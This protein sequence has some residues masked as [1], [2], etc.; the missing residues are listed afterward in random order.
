MTPGWLSVVLAIAYDWRLAVRAIRSVWNIASDIIVG[1]DGAGRTWGGGQF[2]P[3][4]RWDFI[5]E[6][7][8]ALP[9]TDPHVVEQK[10]RTIEGRF[11]NPDFGDRLLL[12][13]RERLALTSLA[14][15]GGWIVT[16]D[17]DE[18]LVNPTEFADWLAGQPPHARHG[19]TARF[20]GVYKVIGDVA[21][22]YASDRRFP[23]AAADP[24]SP[25]DAEWRAQWW[26]DSPGHVLHWTMSRTEEELWAKLEALSP[27][28]YSSQLILDCWRA[29]SLDNFTTGIHPGT[30]YAPETPLRAVP[31]AMLR[32][33]VGGAL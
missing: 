14:R 2:V 3:P 9:G 8:A 13:N 15:P 28:S 27:T 32:K 12:Q 10:V 4:E 26:H 33:S 7:C 31:L 30:C 22:V 21:L 17:A 23:L 25:I 19:V 29:T 6:L 16:L 1:W 18:E 11:W 20:T 24:G 5:A